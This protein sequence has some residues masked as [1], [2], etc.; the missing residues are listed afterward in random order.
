MAV[1]IPGWIMGGVQG[2]GQVT[3]KRGNSRSRGTADPSATKSTVL[4]NPW[5]VGGSGHL[6]LSGCP[7]P[8]LTR[9]WVDLSRCGEIR[10]NGCSSVTEGGEV[11]G[12]SDGRFQKW[13]MFKVR[14]ISRRE[15]KARAAHRPSEQACQGY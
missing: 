10:T 8:G 4:A 13:R 14:D 3:R 15:Q 1:G 5:A 6:G 7:T 11:F 9:R 2:S 12:S